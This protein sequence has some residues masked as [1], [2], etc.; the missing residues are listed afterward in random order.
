MSCFVFFFFFLGL[1]NFDATG[2]PR[3]KDGGECGSEWSPVKQKGGGG[4]VVE[5]VLFVALE[6]E[7][8]EFIQFV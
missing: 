3:A 1:L 5:T 6:K 2:V 4:G 8:E 7:H